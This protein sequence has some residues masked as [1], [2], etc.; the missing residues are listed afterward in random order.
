MPFCD[1]LAVTFHRE[2]NPAGSLRA[3]LSDLGAVASDDRTYR[4]GEGTVKLYATYGVMYCSASGAALASMRGASRYMDWLSIISEW[5]HRIT[6]LDVAHDVLVD[7][8]DVLDGLRSRYPSGLV[9]LGRKALRVKLELAI[10]EDGRETGT[11]YVG[12]RSKAR[13][14]AR[15][16]DK[17]QERLDRAGIAGPHRTRYEVTVKQDYGAT[18][19]D[20]AE[21]DRLFWHVASPA[22]LDTPP[23]MPH[24]T[25]DWS[26]GWR[27][28]P[29]PDLSPVDVLERRIAASSE[30]D[31]LASLADEIGPNGRV[32]LARRLLSRLGV[33]CDS[34]LRNAS[35]RSL[36]A[37]EATP[38]L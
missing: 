11:F 34:Q 17:R 31:L 21:P 23:G 37:S 16:Y 30:L 14:T 19:R 2:R 28:D 13:A 33:E 35:A 25:A 5:P 27:S 24:W 18:L 22:L 29:R 1:H 32:L 20:A 12:H 8:A 36:E 7:G 9:N 26:Q 4:L 3:L 6:R 10:R 15:V 38:G